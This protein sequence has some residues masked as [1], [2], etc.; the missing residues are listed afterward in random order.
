MLEKFKRKV[1]IGTQT[2]TG[3]RPSILRMLLGVVALWLVLGAVVS[4]VVGTVE[5]LSGVIAAG[6][7]V[8]A[9]LV[10]LYVGYQA[11]GWVLSVTLGNGQYDFS[12]RR[13]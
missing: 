11:C 10:A 3:G 5:A 13:R 6:A 8:G 12:L 7:F 2:R 9:I 1:G 4:I